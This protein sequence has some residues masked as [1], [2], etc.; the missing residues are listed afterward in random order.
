ML[1]TSEV[2][3]LR[4]LTLLC[5][6]LLGA[7]PAMGAKAASSAGSSEGLTP[8]AYLRQ[9]FARYGEEG[10]RRA[11]T[12]RVTSLVHQ[13]AAPQLAVIGEAFDQGEWFFHSGMFSTDNVP[14]NE[15][16]AREQ[17]AR[18]LRQAHD[19]I[20]GNLIQ[21]AG[22][23]ALPSFQP[24]AWE[25]RFAAR[26]TD[27]VI[28]PRPTPQAEV[29]QILREIF[30][31][32]GGGRWTY[33]FKRGQAE[34]DFRESWGITGTKTT[35]VQ[36]GAKRLSA[37]QRDW[38]VVDATEKGYQGRELP[39]GGYVVAQL[40]IKYRGRG[41]EAFGA[42]PNHDE[43]TYQYIPAD[44]QSAVELNRGQY[45]ALWQARGKRQVERIV[46]AA[47]PKAPR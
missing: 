23:V 29:Q 11:Q 20:H 32:F 28:E 21:L 38:G 44:R 7:G 15:R 13:L 1:R 25:L 36:L 27:H 37:V 43:S 26:R 24:P 12:P 10:V 30:S 35:A 31:S 40:S 2:R 4:G 19:A 17:H 45:L 42:A 34:L 39:G 47:R 16:E 6:L 33:R 3:T 46:E 41:K 8:V 9:L 18:G 14:W 22:L 5:S